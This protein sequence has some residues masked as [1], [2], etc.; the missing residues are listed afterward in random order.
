MTSSTSGTPGTAA[1]RPPA[2]RPPHRSLLTWLW[3]WTKSIAVALVVWFFLRT[4]LVEAFRIPSGSMENTLLIGDFLFVNKALYG[5]EVPIIKSRL[6]AVREPERNDILVFDSVEEAGLKVVK[7]LI[8]MPGDTLSMEK[9]QLYRNGK[10]GRRAVRGAFR[11]LALRGS[12]P[13]RQDA[14]VAASPSGAAGYR[15]YQPDLQEWG[16]IVVPA[17]SFF[18]MGDNRDSSYDGRYWGFLPRDNVRGRP[19]V[20]YFSYDPS[21]WRSVP[22]LTAVRWGRIFTAPH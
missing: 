6:P 4:F 5:A 3:E 16:P 2:D 20:V 1:P 9:G 13:A 11:P 15:Q 19:L 10:A 18:M 12:D 7:R 17:D 21:S 8:G 22:F 14:G